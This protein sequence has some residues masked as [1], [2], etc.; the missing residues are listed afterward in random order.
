PTRGGAASNTRDKATALLPALLTERLPELGIDFALMYPS[1]GLT[2]NA[3]PDDLQRAS[4]RAY[5]RMTADMFVPY[6]ARFAPVAILP[7]QSP[8]HAIGELGYR[9][10]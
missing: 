7:A 2:I 3:M 1:F 10:G 9:G 5:N 8:D 6:A 4:A